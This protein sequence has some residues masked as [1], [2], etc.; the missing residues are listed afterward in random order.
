MTPVRRAVLLGVMTGVYTIG[1]VYLIITFL[2]RAFG[3]LIPIGGLAIIIAMLW[4]SS[5]DRGRNDGWWRR[6]LRRLAVVGGAMPVA[7]VA[8]FLTVLAFPGFIA[9]GDN[10][11]RQSLA[12]RGV[13]PDEI[14][15]QIAAHHQTP[16]HFLQDGAFFTAIPGLIAALVTTGAGAIVLRKRPPTP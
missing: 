3:V 6:L 5:L 1:G 8:A 9:W 4:P 13:S 2:P 11:H 10:Q 14:E 15:K 16:V 12:T 7:A